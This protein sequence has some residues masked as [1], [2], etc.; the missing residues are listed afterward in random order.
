LNSDT[1]EKVR[2]C[3]KMLGVAKT[4][5]DADYLISVPVL[6]THVFTTISACVKNLMGCLQ[7]KPILD[8]E[9]ATKW[10]IHAE[11][12]R[13]GCSGLNGF[14]SGLGKFENRL[15][16]LYRR[17]SPKLGVV[18]AIVASQGDAPVYGTPVNMDLVISSADPISCDA[19]A[20]YL[21]GIDQTKIGYLRKASELDLGKIKSK[22]IDTNVSLQCHRKKLRLPSSIEHLL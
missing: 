13:R 21:I 14:R 16:A 22:E 12:S 10:E 11:L 20:A 15:I 17:L 1:F 3:D 6:K 2:L 5:L 9:T 8:H 18:D 19:V 4:A 7:P